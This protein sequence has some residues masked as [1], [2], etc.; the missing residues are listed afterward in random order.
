M[1][2]GTINHG[3][4]FA[5]GSVVFSTAA[6]FPENSDPG[7]TVL[8]EAQETARPH[9]LRVYEKV[10][11][12]AVVA[13]GGNALLPAGSPVTMKVQRER[14]ALTAAALEPLSRTHRLVITHGSGP[15]TGELADRFA[16][17]GGFTDTTLDVIDAEIEGMLGYVLVQALSN[18]FTCDVVAILTQVLVS[19]TDPAFS[20]PTKPIGTAMDAAHS[21][22]A[23]KLHGWTMVERKN[24][25][26]RVVASP[27]PIE[28]IELNALKALIEIDIVPIC[29]GGGGI[30]V[31]RSGDQLSGI[32]GV[33]D[34]DLASSLLARS[35]GADSLVLLTDVE[36]LWENW[37]KPDARLVRHSSAT[38]ASQLELESGSME[39]KVRACVD[40]AKATGHA[41]FIG[42]L[43]DAINVVEGKSGT[44]IDMTTAPPQFGPS[45]PKK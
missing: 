35:L 44:C 3:D 14:A 22:A 11:P 36:G 37:G 24:G 8:G 28:I 32:E 29:V 13:L 6:S 30:P 26:R 33:I 41:A 9:Q 2:S 31:V 20:S 42:S 40:F 21:A 23:E 10:K 5:G 45:T 27:A 17:P 34:K 39:P 4:Q 15:Q 38:W 16:S 43:T 12:L 7:Q 19:A 25:F 18:A 1:N